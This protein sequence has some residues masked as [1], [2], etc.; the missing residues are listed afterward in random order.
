MSD[1]LLLLIYF[2]KPYNVTPLTSN[3]D[4]Q[5]ILNLNF[6]FNLENVSNLTQFSLQ[7]FKVIIEI[8]GE[9]IKCK[10]KLGDEFIVSCSLKL[11]RKKKEEKKR[12][13]F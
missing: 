8:S 6:M 2:Y 7:R 9:R 13:D 5:S 1:K 10:I 4:N 12:R 3:K 11:D